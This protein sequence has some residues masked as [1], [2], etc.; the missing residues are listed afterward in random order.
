VAG[1]REYTPGAV[2]GRREYTPGAVHAGARPV[3]GTTAPP[4]YSPG[5]NGTPG[6]FTGG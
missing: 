2:A 3:R 4:A 1:R 6:V 5:G